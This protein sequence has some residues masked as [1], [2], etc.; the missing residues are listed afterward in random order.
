MNAYKMNE[1]E[2]AAFMYVSFAKDG[3][4]NYAILDEVLA[5][6]SRIRNKFWTIVD[7]EL[8]KANIEYNALDRKYENMGA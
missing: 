3:I 1:V 6:G 4:K 2:E 8:T 5:S 7:T